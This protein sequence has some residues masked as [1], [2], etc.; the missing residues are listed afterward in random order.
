MFDSLGDRMKRY[1]KVETGQRF[2]PFLPIIA[3]I[4][5]KAFHSWTRGLDRP[6][7]QDFMQIMRSVTRML[8]EETGAIVGYTQSDEISLIFYTD[9]PNSQIFFDGKKFK[10]TSIL[11]S[12]ATAYFNKALDF[13]IWKINAEEN[14][15]KA[16]FLSSKPPALFDCRV[17][18]VPTQQEAINYLIWRENDAARNSIQS[19]GQANFSHKELQGKGQK[20]I[21]EM[22]FQQKGINWD[23]YSSAEKRG[24]Y[25]VKDIVRRQLT[26]EE[27]KNLPPKHEAKANPNLFVDRTEVKNHHFPRLTQI[28]NQVDVIFNKHFVRLKE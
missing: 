22:L 12:M 25:F 23:G 16:E 24:S 18:Q 9:K 4:D 14:F 28:E 26:E 19:V 17:W 5:G 6:F 3:R 2:M 15:K 27:R 13:I 21:Q 8:V 7:D 10:M 1:E 20:E 11:A